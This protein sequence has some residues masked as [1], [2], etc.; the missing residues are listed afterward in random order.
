MSGRKI[1]WVCVAI[2]A[3][4]ASQA[5]AQHGGMHHG[6]W[7]GWH[8]GG[9]HGNPMSSYFAVSGGYG[10][11]YG[12]WYG[13]YA[14]ML[15]IGPG[16]FMPPI[17]WMGPSL[18]AGRG[19]LLPPP[20][21]GLMENDR[22]TIG[23]ISRPADPVRADRLTTL[24]DRLFRAGNFKKAEERYLQAIRMAPDQAKPRFRLAQIAMMRGQYDSGGRADSR[25]GDR[26]ARLDLNAP[27]I[28]ALYAEPADFANNVA[29][30][31]THLQANPNDRDAWLVLGAEWFLSG[32]T[33]KAADVFKRLNDP[34]RKPDIALAAFLEA[35]NQAELRADQR[36]PAKR[37][38][39][40]RHRPAQTPDFP[41][42]MPL[43]ASEDF[44]WNATTPPPVRPICLARATATRSPGGWGSCWGWSIARSLVT[45][46]SSTSSWSSFPSSPTRRRS[47]RPSQEL[48]RQARRA[49]PQRAHRPLCAKGARARRLHPDGHISRGRSPLAG[50]RVQ[51][52][53]PDRP[54][55][56]LEPVSQGKSLASLGGA[57]QPA[58]LCRATMSRSFRSSRPRSAGSGR[59]FAT[60]GFFPRRFARWRWAA[61]RC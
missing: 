9:A 57:R 35:S 18:M 46:R 45:S 41:R 43:L 59:P 14:P 19:P 47:T 60:T 11:C 21:P 56:D 22:Q 4:L 8:G 28:Q 12:G 53:V 7:H 23:P 52:H 17:G 48:R 24:G 32:R 16:G 33:T 13:G 10:G 54:G 31:E 58:R 20:P 39:V 29:R 6:S 42:S 1:V 3:D 2:L 61:P 50:S 34:N 25:G 38:T 30:L 37:R 40:P 49:D 27:D 44:G 26:A 55:R 36:R 15:A 51:H 5:Q